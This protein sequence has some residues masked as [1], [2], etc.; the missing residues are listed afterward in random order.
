MA[1]KQREEQQA[2]WFVSAR[3]SGGF[4]PLQVCQ[5]WSGIGVHYAQ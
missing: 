2:M 4:D 1:I 5:C 3:I